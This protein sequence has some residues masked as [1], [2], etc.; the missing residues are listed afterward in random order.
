MP[1]PVYLL[2]SPLHR[3]NEQRQPERVSSALR[4][5]HDCSDGYDWGPQERCDRMDE[6]ADSV[7]YYRQVWCP[8]TFFSSYC[9]I[10]I[11]TTSV[12]KKKSVYSSDGTQST[13]QVYNQNSQFSGFSEIEQEF[14]PPWLRDFIIAQSAVVLKIGAP[15]WK[16]CHSLQDSWTSYWHLLCARHEQRVLSHSPQQPTRASCG[17]TG[18]FRCHAVCP[19][20]I[21]SRAECDD[22]CL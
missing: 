20:R 21:G 11:L 1:P 17:E 12:K 7:C 4:E 16:K 14:F 3:R 22:V 2:P 5:G 18:P 10:L 15:S 13:I 8:S 19:I 6:E 9:G